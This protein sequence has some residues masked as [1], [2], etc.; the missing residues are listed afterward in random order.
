MGVEL[1]L[2]VGQVALLLAAL[3]GEELPGAGLGGPQAGADLV[4]VGVQLADGLLNLQDH[5]LNLGPVGHDGLGLAEASLADLGLPGPG[6]D[7]PLELELEQVLVEVV[8]GELAE[9]LVGVGP[10][11]VDD[12]AEDQVEPGQGLVLGHPDGDLG[13]LDGQ[14]GL[15]QLGPVAQGR[16]DFTDRV[17]D[18]RLGGGLIGGDELEVLGEVQVRV[19]HQGLDRVLGVA[20]LVAQADELRTA[21]LHAAASQVD[22]HLVDVVILG[23]PLLEQ[24]EDGFEVGQQ[25]GGDGQVQPSLVEPPVGLL[26]VEERL[27]DLAAEALGADAAV[28]PAEL[29]LTA[30]EV[31]PEPAQ[32]RLAKF[33][34]E[35][36]EVRGVQRLEDQVGLGAGQV[37]AGLH[38]HAGG[39][40]L[41]DP[42][43]EDAVLSVG[44]REL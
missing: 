28:Q 26:D 11:A 41:A 1:D 37:V 20:D 6:P 25:A 31:Q 17:E 44:A 22:L 9:G 43:F 8:L 5:V 27:A 40:Q 15:L 38:L 36:V 23:Q 24:I 42:G 10:Q 18:H 3:G 19:V 29:D 13:L 39:Q 16:G 35:L 34:E 4:V 2:Q 7:G 32:Q 33:H 12:V 30:V 14:P 21:G